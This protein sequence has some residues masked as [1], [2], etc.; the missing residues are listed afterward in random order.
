MEVLVADDD[1]FQLNV[2]KSMLKLVGVNA[3]GVENGAK[4]VDD[5]KKNG[6]KYKAILL[7]FNMPGMGGKDACKEIRKFNKTIKI[8]ALSA[9][10][11][12][13]SKEEV[14]LAGFNGALMKPINKAAL[15]KWK[16]S[17]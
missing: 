16:E 13:V 10:A 14:K 11:D 15:T 4:A 12:K 3:V 5:A 9:D 1:A 8:F 17:L 6:A 7:D 2:I